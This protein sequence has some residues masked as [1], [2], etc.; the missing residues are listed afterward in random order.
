M[1]SR[2]PGRHTGMATTTT[3][4]VVD[5]AAAG[6][7]TA[8][9]EL[10]SR[11]RREL[12]VHC[13]RML[14]S[15]D[16]AEDLVQETFLRAWRKRESY[17]GRATFRAWL[18]G[19]A[20]HA[21]LD[22]LERRKRVPQGPAGE[23]LWL[24]PYPDALLEELPDPGDGPDAV[25]QARETL[26][27]AYLVAVQH[28][29]PRPRAVF[30]LRDVLGWSAPDTA[31]L[32]GCSVAT[33][34]SGLQRARETVRRHL[35]ERRAAWSA[36]SDAD[37]AQRELLARYVEATERGDADMLAATLAED[38]T[39]AMPPY[40]GTT[41][42]R[43]AALAAWASGGFGTPE[44]G[45]MRCVLT[46]ANG[47]PVVANYIRRRGEDTFRP[48]ALDVLRIEQGLVADIVTFGPS[49]FARFD[50]PETL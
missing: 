23:V 38:L 4:A 28:V 39:W 41:T 27:L 12:H 18:Y 2:R 43:D 8:F 17:A 22:A 19:I 21:C 29:P 15:F 47:Q 10:T 50:V 24:Q 45:P 49:E 44:W 33:V 32:L 46:R 14:G 34:T 30:V 25:V 31:E 1:S 9:A 40:P 16:E 48:M 7:E 11:H 26:E 37:A 42:T 36:D 20:T 3:D 35:P 6:D 5:R 13:Y